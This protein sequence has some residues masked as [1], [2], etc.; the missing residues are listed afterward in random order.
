[1]RTPSLN[2]VAW[3]V[4]LLVS[5]A[6]GSLWLY[7]G[8]DTTPPGVPALDIYTPLRDLTTVE[9]M[10][11]A[12]DQ[13]L[14]TSVTAD[15]VRTSVSLWR[16]MHL[17]EWNNVPAPL[18]EQ[19]LD[20][21]LA[22][23]RGILMNPRAW[24]AMDPND[25]D[26]VPQP[27]RTLAYRQ[28]VSYWAGY[29]DVGGDYGLRP[30]EVDDTLAAIVMSESWFNHRGLLVNTD[31]SLDMGL[32]GASGYARDRLRRLYEKGLVDMAPED[33][34]YYN[35]WVA[36]R[37]VAIW[38]RMLINET[39]GDLQRSIRAYN[40]GISRAGDSLGTLYVETVNRRLSRFIRNQNTPPAWDYVWRRGREIE[41][42]EWPWMP[43]LAT[44]R[45]EPARLRGE[46]Q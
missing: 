13:R 3:L 34:A 45:P 25:W 38:M 19:A 22:R 1:M 8:I 16:R 4:V 26:L 21:M 40:R 6:A 11:R 12:G 41:R 27:M 36:T 42:E 32:G 46:P 15:D 14:T 29:Y 20:N 7:R 24:D 39:K 31:G 17:A 43:P 10:V 23:Y 2:A 33:S 5:L 28:M 35:P 18:R 37:F 30:G 44:A 9:V